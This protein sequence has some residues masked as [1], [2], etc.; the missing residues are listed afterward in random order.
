VELERVR[1]GE[2]KVSDA[3]PRPKERFLVHWNMES[4]DKRTY[5]L[6]DVVIEERGELV[7]RYGAW[8]GEGRSHRF[9]FR[10]EEPGQKR[11]SFV[12]LHLFNKIP[13][14]YCLYPLQGRRWE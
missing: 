4:E 1:I 2:M 12:Y 13:F 6:E 10:R 9:A 8:N 3:I 7:Y 5:V 14:F 11:L